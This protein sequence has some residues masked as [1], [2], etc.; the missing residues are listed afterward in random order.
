MYLSQKPAAGAES[1]LDVQAILATVVVPIASVVASTQVDPRSRPLLIAI[2]IVAITYNGFP[3]AVRAWRRRI[4]RRAD[5]RLARE[6]MPKIRGIFARFGA[7]VGEGDG[8][9]HYVVRRYLPATPAPVLDALKIGDQYTLNSW[10]STLNARVQASQPSIEEAVR[11]VSDLSALMN[12]YKWSC[13][14]AVY[15]RATPEFLASLTSEARAELESAREQYLAYWAVVNET[16]DQLVRGVKS[17]T[18]PRYHF[19][20]PK[21]LRSSRAG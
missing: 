17:V 6:V 12:T 7:F 4:I 15:D 9:L 18:V 21:P 5:A 16:S 10:W 2:G 13:L 1:R 14:D 8:T 20:K 3:R 19:Q 11:S